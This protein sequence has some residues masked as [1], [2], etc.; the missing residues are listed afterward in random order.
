M[1]LRTLKPLISRAPAT[2]VKFPEK[3]PDPYYQSPEW[4]GKD[5]LRE[6][7]LKRANYRCQ[8]VWDGLICGKPAVVADHIVRRRDGG[9][10]SEANGRALCK[11]CDNRLKEKWDG[12]RRGG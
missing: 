1:A 3:R 2:A 10:D 12:S 11:T 9:A 4:R 6:R 5:G 7:I 8:A